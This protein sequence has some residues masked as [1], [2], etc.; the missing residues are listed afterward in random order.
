MWHWIHFTTLIPFT[1][2]LIF[3]K[4]R[5]TVVLFSLLFVFQRTLFEV[6]V[7][8]WPFICSGEKTLYFQKLQNFSVLCGG[9][10][11]HHLPC[12]T[13]TAAQSHSS[14][15]DLP[16]NMIHQV[17]IKSLPQEWLW[18]ETWCDDSSKKRAKTIDLVSTEWLLHSYVSVRGHD[19]LRG[20]SPPQM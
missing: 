16:N 6:K 18:C 2:S 4:V 10:T 14:L 17:P 7:D 19:Q 8:R 9:T 5:L 15:Q 13:E 20:A 11:V 1:L 3:N 12:T